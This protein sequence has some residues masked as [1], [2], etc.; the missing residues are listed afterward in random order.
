MD[1][2]GVGDAREEV[3]GVDGGREGVVVLGHGEAGCADDGLAPD[4]RRI[5]R[6]E[7]DLEDLKV[8]VVGV[9]AVTADEGERTCYEEQGEEKAG[10]LHG[11]RVASS[12]G[13]TRIQVDARH[14]TVCW[15]AHGFG[16]ASTYPAWYSVFHVFSTNDGFLAGVCRE[17]AV[18]WVC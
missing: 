5:Q 17:D 9:V 6:R 1:M 13:V 8:T 18:H 12:R 2:L 4:S 16:E 11:F 15:S 3:L 7:G 10:E 14:R